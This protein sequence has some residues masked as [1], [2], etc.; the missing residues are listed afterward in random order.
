[1]IR[2]IT[3]L[4]EAGRKRAATF[5]KEHQ[6]AA[7]RG[8]TQQASF[9]PHNRQIAPDGFR[10]QSASMRS[11]LG[12]RLLRPEHVQFLRPEQLCGPGGAPLTPEQQRV[13]YG[14]YIW[15]ALWD[16]LAPLPQPPTDSEF[17]T[18]VAYVQARLHH[19]LGLEYPLHVMYAAPND[20]C[21]RTGAP[22]SRRKQ[23]KLFREAMRNGR[24][25]AEAL[26]LQWQQQD[27]P[28]SVTQPRKLG[29]RRSSRHGDPLFPHQTIVRSSS[30]RPDLP[31][32]DRYNLSPQRPYAV[33]SASSTHP[34][35]WLATQED[36]DERED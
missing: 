11:S 24:A 15:K 32:Y 6:Q 35:Y 8:R 19:G 27:R 10:S 3:Q 30:S 23:R 18:C 14:L 31:S 22:W 17:L 26:A 12:L 9:L 21:D 36:P 25:C 5:T 34:V 4:R 13:L 20:F 1:M 7:A 29:Q 2:R 28:Q 16:N 33:P